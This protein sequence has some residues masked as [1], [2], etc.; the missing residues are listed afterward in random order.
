[1]RQLVET[2]NKAIHTN[3]ERAL[4]EQTLSSVFEK[5]WPDLESKLKEIAAQKEEN[6]V[7]RSE[8]ALLEEVL[9]ILRSPDQRR[10]Q[11]LKSKE[12]WKKLSAQIA[13]PKRAKPT[14]IR[15][16]SELILAA[17][18]SPPQPTPPEA[19]GDDS[20]SAES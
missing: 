17:A 16:L 6:P 4:N 5:F 2:T 3:G 8:R 14:S 10:L 1:M 7:Q 19:K 20:P 15:R 11:E 9:K 12:M 18:Q 13:K